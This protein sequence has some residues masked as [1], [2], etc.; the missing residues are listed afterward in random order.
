MNLPGIIC[1]VLH[2]ST[3]SQTLVMCTDQKHQRL[4][5][6]GIQFYLFIKLPYFYLFFSAVSLPPPPLTMKCHILQ[7]DC[8]HSCM[9]SPD[10]ERPAWCIADSITQTQWC[11]LRGGWHPPGAGGVSAASRSAPY[12]GDLSWAVWGYTLPSSRVDRPHR[13]TP[14]PQ[15]LA[16]TNP[17]HL[18]PLQWLSR[19]I[20]TQYIC[21]TTGSSSAG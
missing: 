9:L 14:P 15:P 4:L 18:F 1:K 12:S 13:P 8:L 2:H 6:M 21:L 3:H 20:Y 19:N 10:S 7:G 17:Q 5:F 11:H 16:R